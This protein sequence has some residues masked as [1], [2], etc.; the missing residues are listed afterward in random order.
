VRKNGGATRGDAVL[1]EQLVE[2]AKGIVNS[3]SSLEV[4]EIAAEVR[5][6]V[7]SFLFQMFGAMLRTENRRWIGD[8]QAASATA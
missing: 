8:G 2:S 4:L 6:V 3:L 7:G 5:V 1:G